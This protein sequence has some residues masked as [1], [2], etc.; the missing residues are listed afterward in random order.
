[1]GPDLTVEGNR[2]RTDEWLIDDFKDPPAYTHGSIMPAFKNLTDQQLNAL[3]AFL[4]SQKADKYM[5][6]NQ[7]HCLT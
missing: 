3:T 6:T 7:A 2:A 1:M 4:Q 5:V